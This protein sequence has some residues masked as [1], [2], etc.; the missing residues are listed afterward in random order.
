[1]TYKALHNLAGAHPS[2]LN[3][4]LSPQHPSLF[5]IRVV[6]H[7]L[8]S[9]LHAQYPEQY[10]EVETHELGLWKA[11]FLYSFLSFKE[12]IAQPI[13]ISF[14]GQENYSEN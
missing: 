9:P 1:M 3:S 2:H 14:M 12:S 11:Y 4:C 6:T 10:L 5:T 7:L 13:W 8:H